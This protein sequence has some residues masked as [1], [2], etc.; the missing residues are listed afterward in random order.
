[1]KLLICY[2][3]NKTL[4]RINISHYNNNKVRHCLMDIYIYIFKIKNKKYI[5]KKF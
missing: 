4:N 5:C 3:K 1:M 2:N